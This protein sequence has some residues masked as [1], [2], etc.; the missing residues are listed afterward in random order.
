MSSPARSTAGESDKRDV[1]SL[2][3]NGGRRASAVPWPSAGEA[4]T[5]RVREREAKETP[6]A[7]D[8][9]GAELK[10]SSAIA[11]RSVIFF[12]FLS[13]DGWL[14][15]TSLDL[16]KIRWRGDYFSAIIYTMM[17]KQAAAASC[18]L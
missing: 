10:R 15:K 14:K 18:C 13:I 12:F 17:G 5:T 16:Q 2:E 7:R 3:N 6:L 4:E 11:R 8:G 9:V 1:G